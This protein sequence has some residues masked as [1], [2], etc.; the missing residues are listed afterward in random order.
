MNHKIIASML[1]LASSPLLAQ[2]N[3]FISADSTNTVSQKSGP[4]PISSS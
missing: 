2:T 4:K 1:L 3:D